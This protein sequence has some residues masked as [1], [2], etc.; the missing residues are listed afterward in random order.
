MTALAGRRGLVV[1]GSTGIGGAIARA[2]S[3]AGMDV[4]VLSRSQPG[5]LRW[6]PV[7]L[8]DP[9]AART[10]LEAAG[11]EPLDA[12]A[13]SAVSYGDKRATFSD[14]PL[15]QWRTQVEVNLHGLWLTLAATLPSLRAAQPGLF[16]N[17]SSEV[18]FNGGPG[19]SGY[20]ATKAAG[21]SLVDS[22]YQEE[23]PD[24]VRIVS[25]LPAGM[26]DSPGIR[27][28]RP[29]DFDYSDYM[30]PESFAPIALTL[31]TTA[32]A[33][34]NGDNLVVHPD[35]TWTPIHDHTPISQSHRSR[36]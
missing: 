9:E 23:D 1:G 36:V 15:D 3:G 10:V 30:R 29:A 31:A 35:G 32:G 18:V 14:T 20:A 25:V 16:I 12:V 4:H 13:F 11:R 17:V 28:R 19:R 8:T 5:A 6:S 27:R 22:V 21:A 7:D 26:V 34:H 33:D 24:L 2:W